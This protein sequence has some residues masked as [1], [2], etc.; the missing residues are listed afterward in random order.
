MEP[1][2]FAAD[3][4]SKPAHLMNLAAQLADTDPWKCLPDEIRRVV[5]VG[6]GSSAY[7]AGVAAARLQA[8]GQ[9]AVSVLA[10]SS[11]LPA[12]REG[13]VVVAVSA[14]GGSRETLAAV[15]HYRDR[16]PLVLLT[17]KPESALAASLPLV[18]DMHAGTEAGGVACRSF[19][20]TLVHLLALERHLL[21]LDRDLTEL[22]RAAAAAT[23]DL[24]GRAPEWLPQVRRLLDGPQGMHVAAPAH[25]LSSAQQSALMLREG[26]RRQAYACE[27]GDWSHV[28]VYLTRTTDYRL[29]LLSGARW[30]DEMMDWVRQRGSTVVAVGAEV[31]GAA[32]TL[33]YRG[34]TDDDVRLLTETLVAELLASRLWLDQACGLD[35]E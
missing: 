20:H 28:D 26:P 16:A 29:L 2:L 32:Y 34:D 8:R 4:A 7:A 21:G 11:L 12:V 25:R 30:E 13:D 6:M 9:E 19:Q 17:N 15:E 10:S 18:V 24:A 5:L 1:S 27:T 23:L 35:Q 3:L 14:G 22:V 31:P 33:R